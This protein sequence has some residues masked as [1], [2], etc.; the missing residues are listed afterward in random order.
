MTETSLS[1]LADEQRRHFDPPADLAGARE[2]DRRGLRRA[3]ADRLAF[4]ESRPSGSTGLSRG[5]QVLDWRAAVREVVRRR[6]AQRRRQL[7]RP[8]RR[9]PATATRSAIH[10]EGEPGDTPHAHLRRAARPRSA[11]AA[12]ALT[13]LGVRHGDRV[14]I[15]L[16]MIPEAVIAMLACARLGAPHIG[17]VRRLLRRRAARP[18][19]RRRG[20]S[21]SITA[22]GGYRRGTPSA[23]KPTVDEA[24]RRVPD[25][26]RTCSS[27]G[28]PGRTSPGARTRRVVARRRRPAVRRAP[29]RGVRRRAPAVHP[30]HLGHHRRSPR[31][32][33]TPPAAT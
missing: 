7:R 1:A 20:A 27:S 6:Q 21:W 12:N 22:D 16:P 3:A 13:E 8:A 9:R 32:S 28:A 17:R 25:R 31:A 24:A 5:T 33:C 23:L 26:R 15:Y 19:R 30:L 18:D 10:W 4:W 14:A 29:G 11:K 2:R